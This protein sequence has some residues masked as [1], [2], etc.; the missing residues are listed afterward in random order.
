MDRIPKP[1]EYPKCSD[2]YEELLALAA[3]WDNQDLLYIHEDPTIFERPFEKV[4]IFNAYKNPEMDRQIGDRRGRNAVEHKVWGPSS[5]L[6]TGAILSDVFIQPQTETLRVSVSDRRDFYH[7]LRCTPSKA[8][9]N[10]IGSLKIED[11]VKFKAYEE[12]LQ[13]RS[14]NYV[15]SRDGDRLGSTTT[16]KRKKG[17][18]TQLQISFRG[19][20]Q[21]DHGGVEYATE[22]H[23]S[24]LE[25]F[26]VL[27][28]EERIV[29]GKACQ[30]S[31]CLQ[32][33]VI[34]DFFA[35]SVE[36]AHEAAEQSR[37]FLLHGKAQ[38]AYESQK[39]LGSPSKDVLASDYAKVIGAAVDSTRK[40]VWAVLDN[41]QST[42][43]PTDI[44]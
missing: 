2:S 24:L 7:Q 13:T 12:F 40:T 3:V 34:D 26:G 32:G 42:P 18:P 25:S 14:Q 21:G 22:A 23:A 17:V 10:T 28:E 43:A 5:M 16:A 4:R 35:I 37:S 15:R 9:R 29:S 27:Q 19:I 1:W 41:P 33:L 31:R 39:I 30:S 44:R 36:P 6:P 8:S 20:L 11:L 38:E